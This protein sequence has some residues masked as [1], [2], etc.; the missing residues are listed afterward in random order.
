MKKNYVPKSSLMIRIIAGGYLLY[1]AF[2]LITTMQEQTIS[3]IITIGC[4][5]LF[6]VAGGIMLFFSLKALKNREYKE[7][8]EEDREE[9]I[10]EKKDEK[11]EETK[12]RE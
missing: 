3:P 1:L 11:Q 10:I 5:I 6:T 12:E 2:Q 4:S 7:A 9:E 8:V